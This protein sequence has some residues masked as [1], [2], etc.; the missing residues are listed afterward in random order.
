MDSLQKKF[1]K[2]FNLD[3]EKQRAI[4]ETDGPTLII[5][6]PGTGKTYMLV[7]KTLYLLLSGRAKPAEIVLTSFTEKS[8]LELRDR[9]ALFARK[10]GEK[11]NLHEIKLGTI[12]GICDTFINQFI[13]HTPLS[14]NFTILDDLTNTLF[15]NE[16]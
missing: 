16:N 2:E 15:I 1:I 6:G 4:F 10:F 12:H 11:L 7:L 14:K 13:R 9:L 5:A 3:H 8:S